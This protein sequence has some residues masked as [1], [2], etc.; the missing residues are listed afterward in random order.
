MPEEI[1]PTT[2]KP[3][4]PAKL[5]NGESLEYDATENT[6][7]PDSSSNSSVVSGSSE[8]KVTGGGPLR[9]ND[10][11]EGFF[12]K[13]W[14][15]FNVYLLVFVLLLVLAG[16]FIAVLFFK[17]QS[18]TNTPATINSQK[19]SS[20]SLSK[21][22]NNGVQVGDPQQ[23]LNVQSNSVFA[24][25][26]LVKGELQVAGGLKIGGGDL[27]VPGLSVSGAGSITDL[28][29]KTLAVAGDAAM[30]GQLTVG[31]NLNVNGN[32]TFTG[33]IS[34]GQIST[35][36]LQLNGDLQLT[37]HL[38]AGG[39][40]PGR[41]NGGALGA[42]GT[43]SVSGSDTAG[44][45]SINTGSG[46]AAGCFLTVNFTQNFAS[47]PHIIITPVGS[48]AAGI[49]YYINRTTS[50]FS[51]CTASAPPSNQS[52]GFDYIAFD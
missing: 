35:G 51:V 44:S 30:Q 49:A 45:I 31:K 25:Q 39:G 23:V 52:F 4:D 41:S 12:R 38:V 50:N 8:P 27:S 43:S 22:A 1:K 40:I 37:R 7:S 32:G 16:I 5:G 26:V 13:I 42:G 11:K 19:L 29:T 47:T 9:P 15:V 48:G 18:E 20:D 6:I 21:L 3:D 24:G 2:V 33:N 10:H 17:H 34:A 36:K 46:A 14:R 28:Q